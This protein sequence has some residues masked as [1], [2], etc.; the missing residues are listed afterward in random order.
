M[1][2]KAINLLERLLETIAEA[3]TDIVNID[4]DA[5]PTII[6]CFRYEPT[7]EFYEEDMEVIKWLQK[8][9]G[10]DYSNLTE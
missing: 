4:T 2:E 6:P 5:G 7:F 3:T 8:E 9:N 1:Q 10:L